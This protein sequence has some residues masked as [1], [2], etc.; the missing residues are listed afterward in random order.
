MEENTQDKAYDYA[1]RNTDRDARRSSVSRYNR[2]RHPDK[3]YEDMVESLRMSY[4]DR[5]IPVSSDETLCVVCMLARLK[6]A[7]D[8][9]ELGTATGVSGTALLGSLPEAKLTTIER[10]EDF[11]AKAQENFSKA[12][13]KARAECIL[14]DA[15]AEIQRLLKEGKSYDFIFMDCAKVQYI[16]YLPVL[17][18]LL[19]PGGVLVADDVLIY[20]WATGENKVPQ[21]RHMLAQHIQEYIDAVTADED[22]YTAVLDQGD[23]LAVSIRLR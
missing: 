8:I 4:A 5:E 23:G 7:R 2:Y 12:G 3:A 19:R 14:G 10:R 1:H 21:K 22:L 16:K 13:L 17:K 6:G 9:L 11:L 20:G 15:G 18:N